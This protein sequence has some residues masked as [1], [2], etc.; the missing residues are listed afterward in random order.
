MRRF[1]LLY[2]ILSVIVQ[3]ILLIISPV[4]FFSVQFLIVLLLII[5]SLFFFYL[6][7]KFRKKLY[8]DIGR[9]RV[10]IFNSKNKVFL[11]ILL[12]ISFFS[13]VYAANFYTGSFFEGYVNLFL[14]ISNYNDY[15]QFFLKQN[16]SELSV[17]KI[18]P[19]ISMFYFKLFFLYS[20]YNYFFID[21]NKFS[22]FIAFFSILPI[23]HFSISRG[24]SYEFFEI[25][26]FF[27]FA[28]LF[29]NYHAHFKLNYKK[30]LF[31]VLISIVFLSLY[32][33]NIELRYAQSGGYKFVCTS[34]MCI[35]DSSFM[36]NNFPNFSLLIY[37]LNAYFSF[38]YLY[39]S[40]LFLYIFEKNP[41][42]FLIPLNINGDVSLRFLCDDV[43]LKCSAMW[44]PSI[45]YY[46][47]NYSL[48]GVFIFYFFIGFFTSVLIN[49]YVYKKSFI[50]LILMYFN[51]LVFF[52]LPVG[53][54]F[55]TSSSNI[56]ILLFLLFLLFY[57]K[58]TSKNSFNKT[59]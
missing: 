42:Y 23:V 7:F 11:L 13:S 27:L 39:L 24:T 10:N 37:K 54:L 55:S 53:Y 1:I 22:R 15:Q 49:S 8:L 48:I 30:I 50:F 25:L 19:I 18:F 26:M 31:V 58:V 16:L 34:D 17:R 41:I 44:S 28:Y 29:S 47:I 2:Y 43:M 32:Q 14:G 59:F 52:S 12:L 35:D 36:Y 21:R 57:F 38:G 3:I 46:L 51:W 4:N 5:F 20:I 6:G 33:F 9:D 56:L 40:E 45:E